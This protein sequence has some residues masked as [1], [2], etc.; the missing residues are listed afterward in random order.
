MLSLTRI[1]G[2]ASEVQGIKY[3]SLSA[4][5]L[6]YCVFLESISFYGG[7]WEFEDSAITT[8][9]GFFLSFVFRGSL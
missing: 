8:T 3:I 2:H 6:I 4:G 7:E 9:Q 5:Y 1:L